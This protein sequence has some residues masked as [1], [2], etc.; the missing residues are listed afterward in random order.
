MAYGGGN[1]GLDD[2]VPVHTRIEQFRAQHPA[3]RILTT[4]LEGEPLTVRAEV[5][6]DGSDVPNATAHASEEGGMAGRKS[7]ALEKTETAAVGRALAFCGY[8][9]KEGI[10]SR[11]EVQK[12]R[13]ED[14]RP[15]KAAP[16]KF[17]APAPV[18]DPDGEHRR[19]DRSIREALGVLGRREPAFN[20]WVREQYETDSD[21]HDLSLEV[22]REL[23][24]GL[25]AMVDKQVAAAR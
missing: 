4:I 25:N 20:K 10:A 17:S 3:G 19:L 21:W 9:V 11:E 12:A 15:P 7:S 13:Q 2:Y 16:A 24:A 22:K 5:Y 8:E 23:L 18:D 6:F 14:T 1:K